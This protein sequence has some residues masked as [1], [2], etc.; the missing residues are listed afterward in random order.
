MGWAYCG[1]DDRGREIGYAIRA[2]CD[3]RWCFKRID[4]GL[5]YACGG[6]HGDN[7]FGCGG[8][9]CSKHLFY[10]EGAKHPVC[11]VCFKL[12]KWDD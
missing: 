4:R 10:T 8:Y 3:Q 7:E 11:K 9:F 12:R 1:T 5:S 6:M 2:R